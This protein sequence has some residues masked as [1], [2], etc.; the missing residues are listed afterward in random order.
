MVLDEELECA[1]EIGAQMLKSGAEISRVED[2]IERICRS[3]G[4]FEADVF[5]T[6]SLI[7]ANLRT[8]S[9]LNVTQAR[10]IK[11]VS[12]NLEALSEY[13]DLSRTICRSNLKV[14]EVK[15]RIEKIKKT[16]GVS[17]PMV[18]FS[19]VLTSAT[20]TVF[21][22]GGA[23]AA[24]ISALIGL[25]MCFV[26][27]GLKTAKINRFVVIIACGFTI[28]SLSKMAAFLGLAQSRGVISMG[29]TMVLISGLLFTNSIR[30]M[31]MDNILSGAMKCI[32]ALFI[33]LAI[34]IG[35]ALSVMVMGG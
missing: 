13:N 35:F 21:F 1:L 12:Y 17:F 2:T 32:E 29:V 24:F 11:G 15:K 22:G 9:G 18:V 27:K 3:F 31:F 4:S 25:I 23:Y 26:E 20:F 6:P 5:A 28:S 33:A 19:Y 14:A 30:D 10:R 7:V 16:A 34:Y 8:E